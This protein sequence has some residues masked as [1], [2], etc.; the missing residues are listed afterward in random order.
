MVLGSPNKELKMSK[1]K[2]VSEQ[3]KGIKVEI[4]DIVRK[5][6]NLTVQ[7]NQ[8]QEVKNKK[9]RELLELEKE[10]SK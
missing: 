8:L 10:S 5:Q 9:I 1:D 6:E 2:N 4:F 3:I 7:F